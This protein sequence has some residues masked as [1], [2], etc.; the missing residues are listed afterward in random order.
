MVSVGTEDV[1]RAS[2]TQKADG[3][4]CFLLGWPSVSPSA[5]LLPLQRNGKGIIVG[6]TQWGH[7]GEV[8]ILGS[9]ETQ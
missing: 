5:S 2:E 9:V 8:L 4:E 3:P 7:T 1:L 6:S